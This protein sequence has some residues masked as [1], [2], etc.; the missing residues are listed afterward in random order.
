[1]VVQC[2]FLKISLNSFENTLN[3]DPQD[4]SLRAVS[5]QNSCYQLPVTTATVTT[6]ALVSR[7]NLASRFAHGLKGGCGYG[8]SGYGPPAPWRNGRYHMGT[9]KQL[10]I[11]IIIIMLGTSTNENRRWLNWKQ[12]TEGLR[13]MSRSIY[14]YMQN[15]GCVQQ[16]GPGLGAAAAAP[17]ATMTSYN[18]LNS[19]AI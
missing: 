15:N 16:S 2:L 7:A 11:T 19:N 12:R 13:I 8:C 10:R 4:V 3:L 6:S 9:A 5:L 17:V 14:P 18:S 1:M